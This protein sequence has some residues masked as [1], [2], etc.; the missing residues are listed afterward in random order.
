[1][2]TLLIVDDTAIFRDPV[3]ASL[4]LVGHEVLC[5]AD[6]V[7]AL[8]I[9]R[10]RHPDLILLDIAMPKMDGVAFLKVLRAE[11]SIART[12]VILLTAVSD[13]RY[14]REAKSL[15]VA[16]LLLKSRFKLTL[17]SNI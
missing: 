8:N 5:A 3:A 2:S 16:D 6:G 13:E 17:R 15:G 11:Q 10:A 4:R 7:E 9:T 12:P 1:M 14:A